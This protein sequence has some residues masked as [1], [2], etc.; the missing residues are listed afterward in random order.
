MVVSQLQIVQWDLSVERDDE[1]QG[2]DDE[3][4]LDVPPQLL[5]IHQVMVTKYNL[6]CKFVLTSL[7][8]M[9][10]QNERQGRLHC[11]C[12]MTNFATDVVYFSCLSFHC[13]V[14]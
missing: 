11:V 5:F 14:Q 9:H 13:S 1:V 10:K 4:S 7:H 8:I 6:N 12:Y 3:K 2:T